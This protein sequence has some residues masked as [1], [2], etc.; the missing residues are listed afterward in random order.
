MFFIPL[1]SFL[2]HKITDGQVILVNSMSGHRVVPGG[3]SF[4]T[5]TKFAVTALLEGWR[6]EVM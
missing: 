4:Y 2:Q 1:N 6:S 3:L 5:A